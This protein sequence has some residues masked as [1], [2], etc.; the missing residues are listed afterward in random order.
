MRWVWRITCNSESLCLL[1]QFYHSIEWKLPNLTFSK[2]IYFF[3]GHEVCDWSVLVICMQNQW[4]HRVCCVW[5]IRPNL[6]NIINWK[7]NFTKQL[8]AEKAFPQKY[9]TCLIVYINRPT[10]N[11]RWYRNYRFDVSHWFEK[12]KKLT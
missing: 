8:H 4:I 6:Q 5:M 3:S 9:F 10:T 1:Q 11:H 7:S 2:K 12:K